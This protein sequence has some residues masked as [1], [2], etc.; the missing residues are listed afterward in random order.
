MSKLVQIDAKLF[1]DE[2]KDISSQIMMYKKSI[3]RFINILK[4]VRNRLQKSFSADYKPLL[5]RAS[6]KDVFGIV[7]WAIENSME[8]Q[9]LS[10]DNPIRIPASQPGDRRSYTFP[11]T[12]HFTMTSEGEIDLVFDPNSKL[13]R[14]SILNRVRKDPEVKSGNK[15]LKYCGSGIQKTVRYTYSLNSKTQRIERTVAKVVTGQKLLAHFD[16]GKKLYQSDNPLM[17]PT[18]YGATYSGHGLK[19]QGQPKAISFSPLMT[20]ELFELVKDMEQFNPS[21]ADILWIYYVTTFSIAR[22]HAAGRLHRDVKLENFLFK[23]GPGEI[24]V[25]LNDWEGGLTVEEA[26]DDNEETGSPLYI[27][28]DRPLFN[29]LLKQHNKAVKEI[30]FFK[31]LEEDVTDPCYQYYQKACRWAEQDKVINPDVVYLQ[32][33]CATIAKWFQALN[34]GEFNYAIGIILS[35][36]D[37]IPLNSL[38]QPHDEVWALC[39]ALGYVGDNFSHYQQY[40]SSHPQPRILRKLDELIRVNLLAVAKERMT[41]PELSHAIEGLFQELVAGPVPH[42]EETERKFCIQKLSTQFKHHRIPMNFLSTHHSQ[43]TRSPSVQ[44]DPSDD[45]EMLEEKSPASPSQAIS[46]MDKFKTSVA[47]ASQS[48]GTTTM[49]QCHNGQSTMKSKSQ[50]TPH[51]VLGV[52]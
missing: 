52:G 50:E 20:G 1:P 44:S 25:Y 34:G 4:N 22:F 3:D 43:L 29:D 33:R 42:L 2:S 35:K 46:E 31:T 28:F 17:T 7:N 32:W 36:T 21:L 14:S 39:V 49:F 18:R 19:D 27:A 41:A 9:D 26:K 47:A 8:W 45:E 48:K 30:A 5:Q 11:I 15:P 40:S 6:R 51:V 38:N 12:I 37:M 16:R 13:P 10:S 24:D 23:R